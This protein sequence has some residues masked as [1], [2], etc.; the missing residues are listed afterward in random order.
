[1]RVKSDSKKANVLITGASGLIG[2][3]LHSELESRNFRVYALDRHDSAAPF[4][5]DQQARKM[6]LDPDIPLFA[7]INLAGANLADGRWNDQRKQTILHSRTHTTADLCDA[8]VKLPQRPEVLLSASAMG[9]YGDTGERQVDENSPAGDDFLAEVAKQWEAATEAARASEIRT[10]H[11]RFGLV[12]SPAGGVLPN[13]ILPFRLA[14][15]GTVGSGRQYLSW[16]SLPDV[17]QVILRFLED[18]SLN[19]DFNLVSGQPITN[20]EFSRTLARALRRPRLPPL[21]APIIRLM[22]GEMGDAALLG[23]NRVVSVRLPEE[24]ITIQHPDLDTALQQVL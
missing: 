20:R 4:H 6:H 12:L 5:Y 17:L 15:V 13:F 3:A 19:G 21:P 1:M 2:S 7:V 16:I 23:S 11:M 18:D 10:V 24:G 22:F 8:L 9:Y 14:A